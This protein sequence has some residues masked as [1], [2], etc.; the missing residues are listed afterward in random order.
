MK[1]PLSGE[2]VLCHDDSR[3]SYVCMVSRHGITSDHVF[4]GSKEKQLEQ[5][6]CL[7]LDSNNN[8]FEMD[9][10]NRSIHIL[11]SFLKPVFEILN[12]VK[13]RIQTKCASTTQVGLGACMLGQTQILISKLSIA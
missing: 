13:Q 11:N 2:L 7:A 3:S 12:L 5:N 9:L 1:Q 10:N 6:A 4:E 8:I